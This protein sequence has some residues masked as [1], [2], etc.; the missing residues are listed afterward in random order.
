MKRPSRDTWA[1]SKKTAMKETPRLACNK[2]WHQRRG[3][4]KKDGETAQHK[5]TEETQEPVT[6]TFQMINAIQKNHKQ[7]RIR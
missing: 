7:T 4:S 3:T 2:G 5:T 1:S 6:S